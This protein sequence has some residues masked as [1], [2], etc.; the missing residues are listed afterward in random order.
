ML[1]VFTD[2]GYRVERHFSQ[3]EVCLRMSTECTPEVRA[4]SAIRRRSALARRRTEV[5][6]RPPMALPILAH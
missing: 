6:G 2:A 1:E 3:G 4:A 5:T